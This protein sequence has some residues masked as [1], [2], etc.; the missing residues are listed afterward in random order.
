MVVRCMWCA[1]AMMMLAGGSWAQ[2]PAAPQAAPEM[3]LYKQDVGQWDCDIKFWMDPNGEPMTSKGTESNRML[4]DM[5]ILSEFQGD[6]GGMTFEGCGQF[7]YDAEKKKYIGTW[8]DST[9]PFAS[10]MEG[11]YDPATKTMTQIGTG[12]NPDGSPMKSKSVVV[13]KDG[14][15]V[16]TMYNQAPG[17]A[18]EW[19]KVM[20]IVYKKA[21][22]TR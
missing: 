11:T 22:G 18:D 14:G 2:E 13:Y 12:K 9:S 17:S 15:K 5:W 6:F 7:G 1:L 10:Q 16:F 21:G 20:E 8:V 3:A 19:I 4:G